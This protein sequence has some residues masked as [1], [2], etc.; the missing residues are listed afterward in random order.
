[1]EIPIDGVKTSDGLSGSEIDYEYGFD[2]AEG[3][4]SPTPRSQDF[5]SSPITLQKFAH[6]FRVLSPQS[7]CHHALQVGVDDA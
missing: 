2:I 4:N 6:I 7:Y 5:I 3:L 1:M